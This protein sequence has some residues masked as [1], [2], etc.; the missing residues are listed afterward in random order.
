MKTCPNCDKRIGS[1]ATTCPYCG[2]GFTDTEIAKERKLGMIRGGVA[3]AIGV[4]L[5]ATCAK[6]F[7][8]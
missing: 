1:S 6:S 7:G 8:I 4:A 5:L 2:R 3:I